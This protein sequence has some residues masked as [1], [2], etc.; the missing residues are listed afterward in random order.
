MNNSLFMILLS[1]LVSRA[2][3]A[4]PFSRP[5]APSSPPAVPSSLQIKFFCTNWGMEEPWDS[6]CARVKE[7]G[8]DGVETWMPAAEEEKT[9]MFEAFEKYSLEFIFLSSGSGGDF[10]AYLKNFKENLEKLVPYKPV[11]I[12]CH[13]GK[14]YFSF[15]QNQ[16]LIAAGKAVSD[17][18]GIPVLHETHRG[19]FSFAAHI[20]KEYLEKIPGLRLTLDISHWC[21]VHESM[22]ADQEE[23]VS[24]AISRTDHIHTRVGFPEGPQVN[25]P[26]APE[27]KNVL[28]QHLT[29]WDHVVEAKIQ[30][31]GSLLTITP[32]FGPPDY[33][34]TL[35]YTRQPVASQWDINEYMMN[36][37]KARYGKK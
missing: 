13:T 25:D 4:Q 11:L 17:A 28:E 7:A 10:D 34:P 5:E 20:T 16:A 26:R 31:G 14:E 29:W 18:S 3:A 2:A 1:L 36:L 37:L 8:Y 23:A 35:P 21:N 30:R 32:E 19:R 6:F 27:W 33:M 24:L 15:R 12:N 22:L 9:A